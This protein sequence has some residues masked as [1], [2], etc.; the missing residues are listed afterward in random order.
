MFVFIENGTFYTNQNN[1][2]GYATY[3]LKQI[4]I[5]GIVGGITPFLWGFFSWAVMDWQTPV[6]GLDLAAPWLLV[7]LTL[8]GLIKPSHA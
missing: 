6:V 2:C 1:P 3:M 4:I 7:G 5:G 8:G